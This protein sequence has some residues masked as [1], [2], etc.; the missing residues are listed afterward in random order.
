MRNT[1]P[2]RQPFSGAAYEPKLDR[3]RLALQ[4]ERIRVWA[5]AR[6]W[7]TLRAARL[8]LEQLYTPAYFPEASISANLRNLRKEPYRLRVDKRRRAGVRSGGVW[9]YR[10]ANA[11]A[12]HEPAPDPIRVDGSEPDDE[13]GREEFLREVRRIALESTK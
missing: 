4:I 9:E 3:A 11:D 5:L 1:S 7:F 6:D 12:A 8:D 13:K 2:S 10:I